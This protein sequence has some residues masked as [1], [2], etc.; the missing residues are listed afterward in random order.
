[1]HGKPASVSGGFG[2]VGGGC[3]VDWPIHQ[4]NAPA[5]QTADIARRLMRGGELYQEAG[6]S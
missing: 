5:L 2:L 3:S 6:A 1:L 4:P